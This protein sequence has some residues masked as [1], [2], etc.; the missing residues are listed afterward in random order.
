M[1]IC[2][3]KEVAKSFVKNIEQTCCQFPSFFV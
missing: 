3:E 2:D 1:M